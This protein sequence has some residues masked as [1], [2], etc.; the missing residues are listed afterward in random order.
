VIY[1]MPANPA[2]TNGVICYP[3]NHASDKVLVSGTG[4]SVSLGYSGASPVLNT[5]SQCQSYINGAVLNYARRR[6]LEDKLGPRRSLMQAVTMSMN[7]STVT[8]VQSQGATVPPPVQFQT[9]STLSTR[10][11]VTASTTPPPVAVPAPIPA[12]ANATAMPSPSP[13]PAP[14]AVG[15]PIHA[16]KKMPI[17]MWLVIG[18][19]ALGVLLVAWS[20]FAA[21]GP[22]KGKQAARS[23]RMMMHHR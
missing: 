8:D 13:A 21:G 17:W 20:F 19:G 10:T 22:A 15:T 9:E 4:A 7:P 12:P 6:L 18:L 16:P 14:M 23:G 2:S 3:P 1:Y 11:L 5:N